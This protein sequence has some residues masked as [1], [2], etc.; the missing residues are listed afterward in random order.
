MRW[1]GITD[2]ALGL[3]LMAPVW[4]AQIRV[5]GTFT[6]LRFNRE[7][8]DLLGLEVLIVPAAADRG[9]Y[10]AF[11]QLA[12]GGSP[13]SAVVPVQISVSKIQY[14]MPILGEYAGLTFAGVVSV[15]AISGSLS[16]GD[17]EVL[18]RHGSYWDSRSI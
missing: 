12:E 10:V 1:R 15:D 4:A 7:T 14:P 9:G 16:N 2:L 11:V 5:T 3:S 18:K 8:G 6:T 13:Y 17:K